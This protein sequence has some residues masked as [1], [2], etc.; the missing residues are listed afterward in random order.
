MKAKVE[1]HDVY[2]EAIVTEIKTDYIIG[3]KVTEK[4]YYKIKDGDKYKLTKVKK[5]KK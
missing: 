1:K 5:G 3:F 4:Q 2:I